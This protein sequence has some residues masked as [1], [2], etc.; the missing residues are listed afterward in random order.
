MIKSASQSSKTKKGFT[1]IEVVLVLAI[2]GLIFL[3]V[4]VALPALQRLQRNT[5]RKN[6]LARFLAAL[7]DYQSH[8][9]GQS[10]FESFFRGTE[11]AGDMLSAERTVTQFISRYIDSSCANGPGTY[12]I[13]FWKPHNGTGGCTGDRFRDPLGS[14]YELWIYPDGMDG[15]G[16]NNVILSLSNYYNYSG[17][18]FGEY[19]KWYNLRNTIFVFPQGTCGPTE[20]L[21]LRTTHARDTAMVMVLEGGAITCVSNGGQ[22]VNPTGTPKQLTL[23]KGFVG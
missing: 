3:M 21:I 5:Q 1:I 18:G 12:S 6:D 10:P 2:V 19:S 20:G 9:R 14:L 23:R 13:P 22:P 16:P 8:N 15:W 11:S 17:Y 4:F 7:Q